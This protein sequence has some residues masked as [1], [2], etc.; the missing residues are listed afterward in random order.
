MA[1]VLYSYVQKYVFLIKNSFQQNV[2][3]ETT[4]LKRTR[5]LQ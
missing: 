5:D 3:L 1:Y 4:L 2:A